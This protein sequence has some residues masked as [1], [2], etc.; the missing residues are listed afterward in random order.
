MIRRP[1]RSTQSRSSA[2]SDV[3]KRQPPSVLL[4]ELQRDGRAG[5]VE[6]LAHAVLEVAPEVLVDEF[7]MVGEE[8]EAGRRRA[9]LGA[10]LDAQ[11]HAVTRDRVAGLP[12]VREEAVE[13]AGRD[14]LRVRRGHL[15]ERGVEAV[16]AAAGEGRDPQERR[17]ADEAELARDLV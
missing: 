15:V 1:P 17:V 2:A 5:E 16:D 12:Q 9:G 10:V 11:V 4:P 8:G 6:V 13:R 14:R 7:R 3:Y